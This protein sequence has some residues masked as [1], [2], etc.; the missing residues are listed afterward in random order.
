MAR[1][2]FTCEGCKRSLSA[3]EAYA[4]TE[5]GDVWCEACRIRRHGRDQVS[6]AMGAEAG[7]QGLLP[8]DNPFHPQTELLLHRHWE[9]MRGR[10]SMH[11]RALALMDRSSL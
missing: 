5:A 8:T 4:V 2:P 10:V 7:L 1:K 6:R 11:R 3:Q 9:E